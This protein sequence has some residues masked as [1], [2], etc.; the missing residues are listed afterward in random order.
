MATLADG[1][2]S[3]E[4]TPSYFAEFL[5]LVSLAPLGLLDQST[6]VGC[7]YELVSISLRRFSR[8]L[9]SPGFLCLTTKITHNSIKHH[10][11][12]SYH[13]YLIA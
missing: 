5:K 6:S 3:F 9:T 2:A 12:F 11:G 4:S 1:R 8:P 13:N 10:D 7:R